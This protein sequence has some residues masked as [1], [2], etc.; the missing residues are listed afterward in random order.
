[1]V[2]APSAEQSGAMNTAPP[3]EPTTGT[4]TGTDAGPDAATH[5]GPDNG[6]GPR[7]THSRC[8]TW[9]GCA[10]PCSPTARSPASPVAWLGTS[11]STR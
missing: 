1:M 5:Q 10:A 3:E 11:T 6:Q 9:P 7:V 4:S 8:A 2:H